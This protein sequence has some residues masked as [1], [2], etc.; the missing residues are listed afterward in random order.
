MRVDATACRW[1]GPYVS[2]VLRI[3]EGKQPIFTSDGK[4]ATRDERSFPLHE[5]PACGRDFYGPRR[6]RT[7]SYE[8]GNKWRASYE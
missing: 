1:R 2:D 4:F 3:V 6:Q 8:C 7:C 5:C